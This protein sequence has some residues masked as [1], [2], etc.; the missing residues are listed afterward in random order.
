MAKVEGKKHAIGGNSPTNDAKNSIQFEQ[1][2]CIRAVIEGKVDFLFHRWSNESVA[3]KSN[4]KKGSAIKKTDD[5]ESY[6]HRHPNG[7]LCIM[8]EQ[9]RMAMVT[10]AK[11]KQDPRSPR[12]SC[13]DLYKAAIVPVSY[14]CDLGVRDWDYVDQRRVVI[15][16]NAIT[17]SRPA[18]NKGWKC[19]VQLEITLPEYVSHQ[20]VYEVLSLAGRIN[21][22][23]D[24]RPTFGRFIITEF[25]KI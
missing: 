15:Q 13:Y 1:P 12:K 11:F 4:A 20:D 14:H 24:F 2:Y 22:L 7:N 8:G 10:T 16:R 5:L 3:E 25:E 21:G 17:R 23:G 9:F 18:L 19:E 6:V